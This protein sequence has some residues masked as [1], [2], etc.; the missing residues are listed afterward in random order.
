[1]DELNY[2][3]LVSITNELRFAEICEILEDNE[4]PYLY[5]DEDIYLRLLTGFSNYE[6][7]IY[8]R[9]EDFDKAIEL[10]VYFTEDYDSEN[11]FFDEQDE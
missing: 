6:K 5:D 2:K 3:K 4:I 8:V 9:E 11:L 10:L 1:M 7:S